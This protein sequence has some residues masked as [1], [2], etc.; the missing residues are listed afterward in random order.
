MISF[1][2]LLTEN[3]EN[4]YNKYDTYFNEEFKTDEQA[5]KQLQ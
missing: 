3:S 4:T 1:K 2:Q 5:I